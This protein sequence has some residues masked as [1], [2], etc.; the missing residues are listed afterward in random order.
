[1]SNFGF[2]KPGEGAGD[3]K[4]KGIDVSG[5][6]TGPVSLDPVR[7]QEAVE[8]GEALGFTDRGQGAAS[9]QGRGGRKRP[10]PPP[11]QTIYIRAPKDLAEWFERYTEQRGHRALW[12]SI[13][14]FRDMIEA[15][16]GNRGGSSGEA[17]G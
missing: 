5:L 2:K 9:G 12:Q 6:P 10:A 3:Q 11:S 7:E 16:E 13:K 8:R 4:G 1:M 17:K 15:A 14:D